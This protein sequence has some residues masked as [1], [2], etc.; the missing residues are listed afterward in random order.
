MRL[1]GRGKA[2]E[3][4]GKG[5]EALMCDD[6]ESCDKAL[7]MLVPAAEDGDPESQYLAG[8]CHHMFPVTGRSYEQAYKWYSLAAASGHVGALYSL[9]L[10]YENG[11]GVPQSLS[12]AADCFLKAAE[13]G[14]PQAQYEYASLCESGDV[15]GAGADDAVHWYSEAAKNGVDAAAYA[16][17]RL[18]RR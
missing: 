2:K 6:Q 7:A 18:R 13:K 15:E 4:P 5:L 17:E 3:A 8:R 1:F 12:K 11:H 10:L 9:G 16:L 14:H